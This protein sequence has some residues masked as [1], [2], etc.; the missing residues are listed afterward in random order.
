[1][2]ELNWN[3]KDFR[4]CLGVDPEYTDYDFARR[5]KLSRSGL[6]LIV[7]VHTLECVVHFSLTQE[8]ASSP[9]LEFAVF[10]WD[11]IRL[12]RESDNVMLEFLECELFRTHH[13][14]EAPEK[15]LLLRVDPEIEIRLGD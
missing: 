6:E 8:R 5:Y 7:I 14:L 15:R 3:Q 12:V 13:Q 9:F 4:S 2:P 11:G 1:M 10:V